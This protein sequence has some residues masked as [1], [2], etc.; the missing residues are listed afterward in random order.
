MKVDF[1]DLLKQGGVESVI[2]RVS[3]RFPE[4]I[5]K[6]SSLRDIISEGSHDKQ[7][8]TQFPKGKTPFP[9]NGVSTDHFKITG[10]I[11]EKMEQKVTP[12]KVGHSQV[13]LTAPSPFKKNPFDVK[14]A[15]SELGRGR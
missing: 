1:N 7:K 5:G 15:S 9:R 14:S 11:L 13:T 6:A 2:D 12:A 8:D 10:P 3:D 4:V